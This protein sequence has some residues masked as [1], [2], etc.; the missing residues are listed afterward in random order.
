MLR[1]VDAPPREGGTAP[2]PRANNPPAPPG[3]LN[4]PTFTEAARVLG[5]R[6]IREGG[7]GDGERLA[8][9]FREVTG[10]KPDASETKVLGRVLETNRAAYKADPAAAGELVKIGLAPLPKD[11]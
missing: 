1:A 8:W 2:R 7:A 10:R 6:A 3:L 9:A 11:I 4:D 5:Q